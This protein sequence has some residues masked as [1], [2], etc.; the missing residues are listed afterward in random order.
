MP[1]T[2]TPGDRGEDAPRGLLLLLLLVATGL[3][4]EDGEDLTAA[5][6]KK[7]SLRRSVRATS[8]AGDAGS[9]LA[10]LSAVSVVVL[11]RSRE[12]DESA[13]AA[14]TSCGFKRG[15]ASDST[16]AACLAGVIPSLSCRCTILRAL[17]GCVAAPSLPGNGLENSFILASPSLDLPNTARGA[18]IGLT[19]CVTPTP[20]A[21]GAISA[22]TALLLPCVLNP[23]LRGAVS[24]ACAALPNLALFSRL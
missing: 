16:S 1:R 19:F 12:A 20:A 24:L 8:G 17:D 15:T 21:S 14:A 4:E 22:P 3:D 10:G 5:P 6:P 11:A 7:S 9:L 18:T 23:V 13:G 2:S